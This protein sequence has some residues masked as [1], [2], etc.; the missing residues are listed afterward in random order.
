M[1]ILLK[2]IDNALYPIDDE[3]AQWLFQC[4]NGQVVK[5]K[6]SKPRN[7]GH[8]RKYFAL[9]NLAYDSWNPEVEYKGEIIQKNFDTFREN[10][11]ILAGYGDLT[12]N[13]NG[14]PR[15]RSRSISFGSMSPEDFEKLYSS[16]INVILQKVLHSYTEDDLER[17]VNEVLQFS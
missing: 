14:E 16:V 17:V 9:L 12:F 13:L 3:G 8:H 10:I 15:Y 4:K 6:I 11:Q 5:A 2:K 1:E 7:I